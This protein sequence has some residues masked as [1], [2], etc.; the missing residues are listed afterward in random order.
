M[1]GHVADEL[2]SVRACRARTVLLGVVREMLAGRGLDIRDR[3]KDVVVTNPRDPDKGRV[4]I[5]HATGEASWM[6]PVWE[7]LGHLQGYAQAPE[8]DPD[9]E[10]VADAA[11]ILRALC[12]SDDVGTGL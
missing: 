8:A 12:G 3:E 6:R 5:N 1:A 7:Y 2:R 11:A 9:T 10:P 4:Y